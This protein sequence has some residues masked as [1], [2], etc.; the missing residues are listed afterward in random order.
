MRR[1]MIEVNLLPEG[2]KSRG[3]GR[4][5]RR[6]G[7]G[8]LKGLSGGPNR[9]NLVLLVAAVV[10]PIA[11]LAL[12]LGQRSEARALEDRL[13]A[14]T[15]DSARLADLRAISDSLT[16][17][18][19]M[20]RERVALVERL[21]R[22]RFVWPHLMDEVSRAVPDIVWLV[23]L[24]QVSPLPNVTIQIQGMAANPLAIT[25]FVRNLQAS[26]YLTD[27]QILGSQQQEVNDE[28]AVQAFTLVATYRQPPGGPRTEAV[29]EPQG[30]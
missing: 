17:R 4:A 20:I 30:S 9:W 22:N 21:D 8:G 10:V 11:V 6:G 1:R 24:Q 13:E 15:A 19:Q 18:Q 27:V 29:V 12:W 3:G 14:A 16:A 25:E 5:K 2:Q 28:L 7:A 26:E 23:N